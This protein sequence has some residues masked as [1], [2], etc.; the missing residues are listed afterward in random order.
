MKSVLIGV[1]S[2]LSLSAPEYLIPEQKA[3]ST[4][5]FTD[6]KVYKHQVPEQFSP[7]SI[8][9]KDWEK[10]PNDK[11]MYTLIHDYAKEGKGEDG[12]PNG[13]FFMDRAAAKKV[14]LPYVKKYANLKGLSLDDYM[15][16]QFED[17]F[18]RFDVLGSGFIECE[19]MGRFIK[20]LA[21][22]NTL[23]IE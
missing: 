4:T 13:K 22:D 15:T 16:Q 1:A 20:V 12:K 11:L 5:S 17:E 7:G 19:Q 10:I 6:G 21:Q 3:N 14:T 18:Q 2:A 9:K 23:Q 8:W